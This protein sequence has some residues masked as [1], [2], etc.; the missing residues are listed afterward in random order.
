MYEDTEGNTF[1]ESAEI[2]EKINEENLSI[3][4]NL[5]PQD[6]LTIE[7]QQDEIKRFN[8]IHSAFRPANSCCFEEPNLVRKFDDRLHEYE[9]FFKYNLS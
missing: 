2:M 9:E 6:E 7:R 4:L 5:W 8:K 3:G 1:I